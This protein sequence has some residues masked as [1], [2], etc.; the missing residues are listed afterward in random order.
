[1]IHLIECCETRRVG[2][3]L[4]INIFIIDEEKKLIISAGTHLP[5]FGGASGA[6]GLEEE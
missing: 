3:L 5:S 6:A 4:S 1:M 2:S